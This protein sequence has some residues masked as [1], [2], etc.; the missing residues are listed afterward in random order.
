MI[1]QNKRQDE[2]V[3]AIAITWTVLSWIICFVLE[4]AL[5]PFNALVMTY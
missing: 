3:I 4:Y 1:G 5:S 2:M